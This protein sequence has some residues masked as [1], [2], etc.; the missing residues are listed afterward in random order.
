MESKH[1]QAKRRSNVDAF[2]QQKKVSAIDRKIQE[3]QQL[4]QQYKNLESVHNLQNRTVRHFL[5]N[6]MS[7]LSAVSGYLEL[8]V[9]N[10]NISEDQVKIEKYGRKM[11]DGL[12]EIGFLLEQL[13]EIHRTEDIDDETDPVVE[14]NWLVRTVSDIINN[15]SELKAGEIQHL[16][17]DKPVYIH[18]DISQLKLM[19]YNLITSMDKLSTKNSVLEIE[20]GEKEGDFV[21][22]IRNIGET[23]SN[24]EF[25]RLFNNTSIVR[26]SEEMDEDS[27]TLLGLKICSQIV[28]SIKGSL[29]L[30]K[31]NRDCPQLI[32]TAPVAKSET[33]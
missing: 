13:H 12:N 5:H 11:S 9:N 30:D 6:M 20:I 26:L 3:L 22:F 33:A 32:L 21:M 7:P 1:G 16:E 28:E 14:L 15:S 17:S 31:R 27:P 4:K 25:T 18:A 2:L 29:I 24:E 10:L 19:I 8:L 23:Q